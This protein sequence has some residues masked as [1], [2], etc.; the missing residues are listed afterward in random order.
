MR[1]FEVE[2]GDIDQDLEFGEIDND[3]GDLMK[4]IDLGEDL[5]HKLARHK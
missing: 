3:D 5:F 1:E 4:K 2:I